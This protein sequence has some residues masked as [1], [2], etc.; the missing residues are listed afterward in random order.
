MKKHILILVVLVFGMQLSFSQ[1]KAEK[2]AAKQEKQEQDFAAVKTL[3]ETKQFTFEATWATTQS[4]KRINLIGNPN[5]LILDEETTTGDLPYFGVVQM[6]AYGG[7][8][9]IKFE[10]NYQD[11]KLNFNDKKRLGIITYSIYNNTEN[12]TVTIRVFG[13]E[14]ASV[15]IYSSNRNGITYDGSIKALDL[16]TDK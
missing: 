6:T 9:G 11:Y 8:G 15:H 13:P 3:L 12:F 4:G 16:D 1:T 5:V 7:T 10:G 2:K 14:S